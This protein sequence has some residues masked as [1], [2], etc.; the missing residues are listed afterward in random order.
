MCGFAGFIN[1]RSIYSKEKLINSVKEINLSIKNR[2]PDNSG[3]WVD[4]KNQVAL[5]HRR[6]SIIDLTEEG[7]QPMVSESGRYIISYNGEVYNFNEIRKNLNRPTSS[8]DGHSDTEVILACI[9]EHGLKKAVK[10]FNGMFAFALWDRS[11]REMHLVRDRVGIKPL[12][13]AIN[14]NNLIFASELKPLIKSGKI[15]K[16]IDV[17]SLGEYFRYNRVPAPKT[18][19]E[20]VKKLEPGQI[21]TFD[22]ESKD[23]NIDR[24]WNALNVFEEGAKK[25]FTGS[26]EEG[27]NE[28]RKRIDK[29]VKDRMVSDVPL[30]AFLS[31][32]IDSSLVVATMQ[33]ISSNPVKSF[34]IGFEQDEFN[35]AEHA[36]R[37][38]EYLGTDHTEMYVSEKD[39]LNVIPDLPKY[40]DEPF[41]DSSQIPTYLVSK[42][43]RN[44]VTVALSGD[45]G[46]EMFAGYNRYYRAN[47]IWEDFRKYPYPLRNIASRVLGYLPH[48]LIDTTYQFISPFISQELK[49]NHRP[50]SKIESISS[51]LRFKSKSDIYRNIV[52]HWKDT[53]SLIN[54]KHSSSYLSLDN[55]V[56]ENFI[57]QMMGYDLINYL[58][59]DILTK[60]DRAS[61]ANSLESR[62]PLLDHQI[63]E[64]AW[65]LPFQ[66]KVRNHD[67]KWMLKQ[68]LYEYIPK[69]FLDRPK[70]GFGV[71][72]ATWLR[73]PLR[74]WTNDLLS[75][76][77]LS[78]H[79]LLNKEVV[80]NTKD[81]H[82]NNEADFHY[83]L[84]DLLMFQ[85][86]YNEWM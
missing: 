20:D 53:S 16:R 44:H 67:S 2:G 34:S 13:Y 8:Y 36:K 5:G 60:V 28:L 73:G 65:K 4:E 84:W 29:A 25:P 71:P 66:F 31:G 37:V 77:Q 69:D 75:E 85:S 56:G 55:I 76:E 47:K 24:F 22:L 51:A 68:I 9:E 46:D 72:L 70:M 50:S 74:D 81:R 6:L 42:M 43:T 11:E 35:E 21:L 64:W 38:A 10:L 23:I 40:W 48:Q 61:M 39:A 58:P 33:K 19:F 59:D 26:F 30:G 52:T 80:K 49:F 18:I 15:N 7:H 82:M 57:E 83:Y 27:K 86:W 1:F 41:A 79:N 12:Y 14:Q 63:I 62:V 3:E 54:Y 17:S 32:G 45:G 78:K